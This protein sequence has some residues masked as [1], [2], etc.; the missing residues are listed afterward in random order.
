MTPLAVLIVED[1]FL[2]ADLLQS[3]VEDEGHEV[4][5]PVASARAA[6][7]VAAQRHVDFAILDIRL[8]GDVDGV[9]LAAELRRQRP[10]LGFIFVTGSGEAMTR[11]RAEQ[12]GPLAIL[13]KPFRHEELARIL[14][15]VA[16]APRSVLP[17]TQKRP[18]ER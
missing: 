12:A 17:D 18:A 16:S 2:V 15:Q 8:Q 10:D 1:E 13:Q 4:L 9:Q 5:G 7:E 11:A 14:S 3:L 6:L